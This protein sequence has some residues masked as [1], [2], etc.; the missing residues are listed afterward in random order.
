ML[1]RNGAIAAVL[2]YQ[3]SDEASQCVMAADND[4]IVAVELPAPVL[5]RNWRNTRA[6]AVAQWLSPILVVVGGAVTVAWSAFLTWV[7]FRMFF[8]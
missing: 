3:S 4:N 6:G 5:E 2:P 1:Y 7:A 8:F